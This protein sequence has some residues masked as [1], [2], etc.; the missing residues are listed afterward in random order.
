MIFFWQ[1]LEVAVMTWVQHGCN[2]IDWEYSSNLS[3]MSISSYVEY[4]TGNRYP[5]VQFL[6]ISLVLPNH[7]FSSWSSLCKRILRMFYFLF[8]TFKFFLLHYLV[9]IHNTV[10]YF[11]QFCA[12]MSLPYYYLPSSSTLN[13]IPFTVR[14]SA[15]K[16]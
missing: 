5:D 7:Q 2:T 11:V 13:R 10:A 3:L 8:E 6:I 16:Y 9:N 14:N 15:H 4:E 12:S 1:E